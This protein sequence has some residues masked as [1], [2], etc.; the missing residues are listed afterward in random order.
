METSVKTDTRGSPALRVWEE[1]GP[2]RE[3]PQ[4]SVVPFILKAPE[5]FIPLASCTRRLRGLCRGRR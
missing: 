2:L 3:A 1:P 4:L 5:V